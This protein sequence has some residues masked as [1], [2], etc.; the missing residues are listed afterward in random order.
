[1]SR[2]AEQLEKEEQTTSETQKEGHPN[3]DR[4]STEWEPMV[5]I[6]DLVALVCQIDC[7]RRAAYI[8]ADLKDKFH[9]RFQYCRISGYGRLVPMVPGAVED[10]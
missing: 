10:G 1:M 9:Q 5:S 6:G 4:T 8:V 7:R 3:S 2:D